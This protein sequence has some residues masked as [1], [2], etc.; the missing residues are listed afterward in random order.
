VFDK[1]PEVGEGVHIFCPKKDGKF[2]NF[3][4]GVV[5]G[6]DGNKVGVN[7]LLINPVGLKN[8]IT[9][10]KAGPRSVEIL[11]NPNAENCIFSLIYRVEQDNFT[12][13]L[14]LK[15]DRIEIISP[16][17]FSILEGWIRESIP[18]LVNN[19]LSLAPSS[20]REKAKR[21]LQLK[22]ETVADK[23]LRKNLYSVCRSLKI[24]ASVNKNW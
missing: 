12:G 19:V 15:K 10:G 21:A 13:V 6:V 18:E 1:K 5:T 2:T 11:K 22:M 23:H 14:N 24:L 8:K 17:I 4:F 9:Q 7:G 20:E 16:R 3:V